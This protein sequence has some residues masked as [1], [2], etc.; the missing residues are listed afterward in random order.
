MTDAKTIISNPWGALPPMG[1]INAYISAV[2]RLPM[3][4]QDQESSY[5]RLVRDEAD[6]DASNRLVLSHLR[7]VVSIARQHL[8]YNISHADLIQEGTIGLMKAVERF[9]PDHGVRLVSY[10]MKW[11]KAEIQEY[12]VKNYRSIK[13]ATT[14]SHRKLFFNLRSLKYKMREHNADAPL[15]PAEAERIAQVLDVPC[16]DVLEMDFRLMGGTISL[17]RT[18]EDGDAFEFSDALEDSTHEP[19]LLLEAKQQHW[20]SNQGLREAFDALNPRSQRIIATRWMDVD[21]DGR[22]TLTL[23]DLATE[24]QVSAERVRQIEAKA[25]QDMRLTLDTFCNKTPPPHRL[26]KTQAPSEMANTAWL[27]TCDLNVAMRT[28]DARSRAIIKARWT[29]CLDGSVA[30]VSRADLAKQYGTSTHAIRLV[31]S[32]SLKAMRRAL[33]QSADVT[34][35]PEDQPMDW[36]SSAGIAAA[37]KSLDARSQRIVTS[38]WLCKTNDGSPALTP[39]ELAKEYG[40]STAEVHDLESKA[41]KT[42]RATIGKARTTKAANNFA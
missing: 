28:L 39:D 11:I 13:I 3:L 6:S 23:N 31:E 19:S 12:V 25:F 36:M 5:A 30:P 7:L 1:D 37:L 41:M 42:M 4:T 40:I 15:Q 8:G 18:D 35:A 38:Q 10:A 20:L 26:P 34:L 33:V 2:N 21:N 27:S 16:A 14:K 22:A 17:T 9:D 32:R 29:D 24:L